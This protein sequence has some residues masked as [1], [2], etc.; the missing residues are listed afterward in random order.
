MRKIGI[1][2][3]REWRER[4][5]KRS[6]ILMSILGPLFVLGLVYVLV[7]SGGNSKQHWKVLVTDKYQI[8]D[9]KILPGEE[10]F[11]TYEFAN[12]YIEIEEF[13]DGKRYQEYDAMLEVNEKI[14]SNRLSFVFFREE[15]S[16][17][18]H[19]RLK[20][21]LERRLEEIMV[22]QTENLSLSQYRK[23]KQPINVTFK[24]AYDPKN[25]YSKLNGWTGWFFGSLIILFIA[26]FGMSILR[27]ISSEKSNRIVEVILA[28]VSP[29]QLLTGKIIGV[30]LSAFVQFS[31][32]VLIIGFGLYFFREHIFID[33]LDLS[34]V[35][36]DQ[37][38][39]EMKN[40]TYQNSF[41]T[42][43]EYNEFVELIFNELVYENIIPFFLLFFITGY[44]FYGAIFAALGSSMGSESDGQQ[45]LIPL[46]FIL[47]LAI[48]AGYYA[49]ENPGDGLSTFFHYFPFTAPVV[50]MVKLIQGYGP[51]EVY[52]I[53]LSL[54]ILIASAF[55][56]LGVASRIYGN[57]IL[58]FGHR[59][60]FATVLKWLR[61]T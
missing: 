8:L 2:A 38:S 14:V 40:M 48:Y 52:Q 44:I 29:K 59:L 19:S 15:P 31:I 50:V 57:G 41:Y 53:Y 55:G 7:S 22:G 51:N 20:Y 4:M 9:N 10:R 58:Q 39:D 26:L 11:I 45:F 32:W 13:A 23:I 35:N 49:V 3:A 5:G 16:V 21:Q 37:M 54:F 28:T 12:D 6:F 34:M 60:R 17:R 56:M 46:L 36:F 42:S 47:G 18:M 24:N 25:E 30:G 33:N 61:R 27:S 43:R 1:I